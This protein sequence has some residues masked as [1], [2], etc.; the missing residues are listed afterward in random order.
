MRRHLPLPLFVLALAAIPARAEVREVRPDGFML[1]SEA[2]LPT[3]PDRVWAALVNWSGWWDPAHSYSGQPG[4]LKLGPRAGGTLSESWP[5]GSVEHA[6][7]VNAMPPSLLRLVGGFGPLQS[8]AVNAVLDFRI[9]AEN[10]NTRLTMTYRVAGS[11]ADKLDTLA[12]PVDAVMSAG[13][14]RL[15]NVANTGKP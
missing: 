5:G 6:R 1:V 2:V 14:D 15:L 4:V 3:P 11:A 10:G 12:A 7:V 8:L 9:K 13:F